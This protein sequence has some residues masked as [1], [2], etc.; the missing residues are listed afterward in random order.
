MDGEHDEWGLPRNSGQ[1]VGY[2]KPLKKSQF[3]KGQSGNPKGRPKGRPNLEHL[4]DKFLSQST[5]ITIDGIS[6]RMSRGEAL[7]YCVYSKAM[8]G[9]SRFISLNVGYLRAE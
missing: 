6:R 5:S 1:E 3:K 7:L 8:K 2:C 4:A 9:D